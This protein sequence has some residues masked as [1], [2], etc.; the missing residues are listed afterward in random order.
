MVNWGGRCSGLASILE[1]GPLK[2]P[3]EKPGKLPAITKKNGEYDHSMTTI[4]V[5]ISY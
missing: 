4:F 1:T 3:I 5:Q 2:E